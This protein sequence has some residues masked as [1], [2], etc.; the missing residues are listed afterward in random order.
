[1][2]QSD[3]T[4]NNRDAATSKD[5]W[6]KTTIKTR[7]LPHYIMLKRSTG[8]INQFSRTRR[9]Y[10]T[11][12]AAEPEVLIKQNI[13]GTNTTVLELNRPKA[14][15]A[16][17]LNMVQLMTPSY[18][19]AQ[20]SKLFILK[21]SP[22]QQKAFCAGGDIKDIFYTKNAQFFDE[23]YKLDNLIGSLSVPH[24]SLIDGITMGGGVGLSVH[25]STRIATE[26]TTFAMPET[27]IGFFCDVGG[28]YFLPRLH[29]G[30]GMW[31]ALTGARLKG[32]QVTA[33]GVATHFVPREKLAELEQFLKTEA[34]KGKLT[35]DNVNSAID[36]A[37]PQDRS[38][39]SATIEDQDAIAH[40]FSQPSVKQIYETLNKST[41]AKFAEKTLAQL[42]KMS[43]TSLRV[44]H[45]QMVLGA[46]LNLEQVFDMERGI[47]HQMLKQHDFFEGVRSLLVDKDN[48]F[49]WQPANLSDVKR[50]DIDA[51]FTHVPSS[52]QSKVPSGEE[53]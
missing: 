10:S 53:F 14:L 1:M 20:N 50:S 27:Q 38:A 4:F 8:L 41:H 15:N 48:K 9:H 7:N 29:N 46:H 26:H 32:Q 37:F 47:A 11:S 22:A 52:I 3:R 23:E 49:A 39:Y 12:A 19:N 45:R 36:S 21:S 31:L 35:R 13:D 33:A 18:Q 30:M 34:N 42:N 25:G 40:I 6:V 16:L 2:V 5:L 51:Y 28:G 24:V 17:N 44:V 43:P